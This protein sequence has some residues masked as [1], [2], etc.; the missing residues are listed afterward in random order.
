MDGVRTCRKPS[1]LK[2]L[3][4]SV[5]IY[6]QRVLEDSNSI[7]GVEEQVNR[8]C[9][10]RPGRSSD[11]KCLRQVILL[12]ESLVLEAFTNPCN[13]PTTFLKF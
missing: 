5:N 1:R 12:S 4:S 2:A 7:G 6:V 3:S 13:N 9:C 10:P 8:K 11:Y